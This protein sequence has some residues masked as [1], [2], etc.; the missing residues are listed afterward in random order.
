MKTSLYAKPNS[1]PPGAISTF[2]PRAILAG[3]GVK[4]RE[5]QVFTPIAE[6]VKIGQ[7]TVKYSPIQKL[8]DGFITLLCGAHGIVE[9][10]QRLRNDPGL[11]QAFGQVGCAEQSVIQQTLDA[12]DAENV[13]QIQQAMDEIYR[14]QSQGYRHD[15]AQQLQLLDVDMSG[16][17]CGPKAAFATKGYFAGERNRRGRQLGRVTASHYGEIVI[18]RLFDGK[19]QLFGALQPLLQAAE[20]TL[21]LTTDAV[22]RGR[23]VVRMDCGGGSLDDV[24]WLLARGYLVHTKDCSTARARQLA[25]TVEQWVDDP[26]HRGR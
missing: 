5:L 9:V 12:C 22:K 4:I 26:R 2:S 11:Q 14:Q 19:T 8:W 1:C 6:R 25:Q 24:N 16:Q 20:T 7:K 10:E 18:D 21:N 15:Y 3:I 13:E 23:T 17:P